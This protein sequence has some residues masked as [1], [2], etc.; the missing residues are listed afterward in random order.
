MA[1][2]FEA[3]P[4]IEAVVILLYMLPLTRRS[5]DKKKEMQP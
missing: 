3:G 4:A 2:Q 5:S 1:R